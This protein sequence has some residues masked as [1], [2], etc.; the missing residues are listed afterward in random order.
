MKWNEKVMKIVKETCT[1][2]PHKK[3]EMKEIR[4]MRKKEENRKLN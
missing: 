4:I 3:E 1:I 2:K